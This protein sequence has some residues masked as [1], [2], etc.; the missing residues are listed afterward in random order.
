M[1]AAEWD[2]RYADQELV[3][4]A[5][6]NRFVE[7]EC[8]SLRPGRALDLAAGEGRNAIW[9]ASRGW[10]VTAVDFSSVAL[11]KGRR[12]AEA[13]GAPLAASVSWVCE[14]VRTWAPP[15]AAFDLVVVA[16]LHLPVEVRREVL[17]H[18]VTALAPGATLVVVG[19][20]IANLA[21][22]VG[23]PQDPR[24]LYSPEDL[25]ADLSGAEGI[26]VDKAVTVERSTPAGTAL[27]ALV[28]ARRA[29]G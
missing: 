8:G 10:T 11:D 16:Y 6:P 25:V 5:E 12:L 20:D 13:Q 21:G 24:V 19:H 4:S 1:E 28:R 23:G 15:A 2:E 7:E 3:W 18:A 9:L 26:V 14:D 22:G 29:A 27:D 17:D